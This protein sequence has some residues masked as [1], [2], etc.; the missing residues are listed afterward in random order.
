MPL[1][2]ASVGLKQTKYHVKS[3]Y[4]VP[5]NL[6]SILQVLLH[7]ILATALWGSYYYKL[8]FIDDKTV[9]PRG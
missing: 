7:Q 8:Y 1:L 9:A 6:L 5:E 2:H 4:W 3:S